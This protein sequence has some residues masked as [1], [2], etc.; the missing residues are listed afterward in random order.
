ME[1]PKLVPVHPVAIKSHVISLMNTTLCSFKVSHDAIINMSSFWK[2]PECVR[3]HT[4]TN[5]IMKI[6][7]ISKQV[8]DK[9]LEEYQSGF[10]Y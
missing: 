9:L 4:Y 10:G 2:N 7:E 6:K 3:D 1:T 5:S 8:K